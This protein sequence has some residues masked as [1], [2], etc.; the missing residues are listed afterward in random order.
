MN[1]STGEYTHG[2]LVAATRN[3]RGDPHGRRKFFSSGAPV[4]DFSREREFIGANVKQF[5]TN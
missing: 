2:M 5:H 3:N 1:K 4:M